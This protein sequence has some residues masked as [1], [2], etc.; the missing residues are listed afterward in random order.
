M[1]EPSDRSTK[2][3]QDI[4]FYLV[5]L[6]NGHSTSFYFFLTIGMGKWHDNRGQFPLCFYAL[7]WCKQKKKNHCVL[8]IGKSFELPV[9]RLIGEGRPSIKY[10]AYIRSCKKCLERDKNNAMLFHTQPRQLNMTYHRWKN[11]SLCLRIRT[12]KLVPCAAR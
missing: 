12:R 3:G 9:Q 2:S 11:K 10:F 7:W 5:T 1:T 8:K 6:M 4:G